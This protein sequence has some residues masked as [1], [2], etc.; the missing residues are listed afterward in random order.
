VEQA[1]KHRLQA[2]EK[3]LRQIRNR[4]KRLKAYTDTLDVDC[5]IASNKLT[6]TKK[7]IVGWVDSIIADL[8]HLDGVR[9]WDAVTGLRKIK[10]MMR[11]KGQIPKDA[12]LM[13]LKDLFKGLSHANRYEWRVFHLTFNTESTVDKALKALKG[14]FSKLWRQRM[15]VPDAGA[16]ITFE[17]GVEGHVHLH[18]IYYGPRIDQA[19]LSM[20][21]QYYANA[22]IVWIEDFRYKRDTS[23]KKLVRYFLK[24]D[25][26]PYEQRVDYWRVMRG[27]RLIEKRG[28]FR[29]KPKI[30]KRQLPPV[31]SLSKRRLCKRMP[32]PLSNR[33]MPVWKGSIRYNTMRPQSTI[34]G[35]LSWKTKMSEPYPFQT[36]IAI[37]QGF[38]PALL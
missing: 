22:E 8:H 11:T 18:G 25:K 6:E 35:G 24:F 34:R 3:P 21:W 17:A 10:K 14:A 38:R 19:E 12:I 20:L 16:M 36:F 26:I 28:V 32:D 29:N 30:V 2:I 4:L 5:I 13:N 31:A 37:K 33:I 23:I 27:K 7:S 15:E 1:N 9:V